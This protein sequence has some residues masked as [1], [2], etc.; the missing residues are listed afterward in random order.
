LFGHHPCVSSRVGLTKGWRMHNGGR[1]GVSSSWAPTVPGMMLQRLGWCHS[2]R[3]GRIGPEVT[4]ETCSAGLMSRRRPKQARGRRPYPFRGFHRPL[5]RGATWRRYGSGQ[6]SVMELTP[7]FPHSFC[8]VPGSRCGVVGLGRP[9]VMWRTARG[10]VRPSS[11]AENRLRGRQALE[12]G[13]NSPEG[14]RAL[15]RGGDSMA[16]RPVLERDGDSP[17]G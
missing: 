9:R 6:H 1:G 2:G 13:G 10:G 3:G 8:T 7:A 15:E 16:Q 17:E 12:R 11:E 5:S 14:H 4:K